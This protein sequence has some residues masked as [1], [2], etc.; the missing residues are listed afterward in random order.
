MLQKL[1][2]WKRFDFT[3]SLSL[4]DDDDDDDDDNEVDDVS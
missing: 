4:R 3:C 1:S 2:M